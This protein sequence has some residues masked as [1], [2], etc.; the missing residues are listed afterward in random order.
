[1]NPVRYNARRGYSR[2]QWMRI[3][4]ILGAA[5]D[6]KPGPDTA[7]AVRAYQA[8]LGWIEATGKVDDATLEALSE[9]WDVRGQPEW[10]T[11][12][13]LERVGIWESWSGEQCL[14]R[15]SQYPDDLQRLG[16]DECALMINS[17]DLDPFHPEWDWTPGQVAEYSL[18]LEQ[19]SIDT[20]LTFWARPTV[21]VVEALEEHLTA[22]LKAAQGRVTAIEADLE[23]GWVKGGVRGYS[24][25]REA[26]AA[27]A[28]MMRRLA[29]KFG[30]RVEV[31]SYTGHRE[32]GAG[33]TVSRA[34]DV[35]VPQG[36]SY[37]VGK[38]GAPI[39]YDHAWYG[40][41]RAQE[42]ALLRAEDLQRAAHDPMTIT[43]GLACW[44]Q[45]EWPGVSVHEAMTEQLDVALKRNIRRLRYWA[46]PWIRGGKNREVRAFFT[47]LKRR[48]VA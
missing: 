10:R 44:H 41:G 7:K 8:R 39:P 25:L 24:S 20:V 2:E 11:I 28:A 31:T 46:Y 37:S 40:V 42:T 29:T 47:D 15:G 45:D 1:M 6:G 36:Y 3:Q 13:E 4:T 34:A 19:R 30:V 35:Y 26:G 48:R 18:L 38:D 9:E 22:T 17:S 21:Y 12:G 27:L 43:M 33:A 14:R 32:S 16:F 23:G 5:V